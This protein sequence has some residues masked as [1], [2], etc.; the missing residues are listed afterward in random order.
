MKPTFMC[1][2]M[3]GKL[4]R[5]LRLLGF[6]VELAG[7]GEGDKAIAA[8]ARAEG[9]ILVTRDSDIHGDGVVLLK[10]TELAGQLR[11]LVEATGIELPSTPSPGKCTLCNGE[12]EPTEEGLPEGVSEG[13]RCV[14]CRHLFWVGSHWKKI[15][16]F[17][18]RAKE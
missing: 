1:D 4:A 16:E 18:S 13:W 17:L 5:W 14:D 8:R 7:D 2:A 6:D 15:G 9:R 11:E 3:L 12:L 10:G